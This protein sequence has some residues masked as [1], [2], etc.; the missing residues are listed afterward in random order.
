MIP[1]QKIVQ[2]QQL[3][4]SLKKG[5]GT[6][7]IYPT[8][9]AFDIQLAIARLN[10]YYKHYS[11]VYFT[12]TRSLIYFFYIFLNSQGSPDGRIPGG[13][14]VFFKVQLIKVLSAGIGGS[15]KLFGADGNELSLSTNK[16]KGASGLLFGADG[17][18]L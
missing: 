12:H 2:N 8:S 5:G 3:F 4:P 17:R 13:A 6:K 10:S 11:L 7:L 1:R 18:P 9:T 14:T 16:S 15:A